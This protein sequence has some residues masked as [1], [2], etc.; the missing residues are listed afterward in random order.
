MRQ[1]KLT[2]GAG[3]T[4]DL[5]RRD[6]FFHAPAG[7]GFS[8]SVSALRAGEAWL[9]QEDE[10]QQPAPSGELI[11]AGYEQYE[12]FCAFIAEGRLSLWY[13]PRSTW[14]SAPCIVTSLA[15][16]EIETSRRLICAVSFLLESAWTRREKLEI[17]TE[18]G[19]K[20]YPYTYPY[21]YGSPYGGSYVVQNG[22]QRDAAL[23]L[24]IFGPVENPSWSV[25]NNGAVQRGRVEAAVAMGNKIV[26]DSSDGAMEL[27][28]YTNS[29]VFVRDLYGE[30]D[31][32]T[33]R[34]VRAPPGESVVSF[35]QEGGSAITAAVE[36]TF[37]ADTV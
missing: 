33:V 3:H 20:I 18:Q 28:E 16:S 6:A 13:A 5:M 25:T 7:L 26:V 24:T 17:E 27:A 15:K 21:R 1:F 11:F 36:V 23:R 37:Y 14:Y 22:T 10:P 29:N 34:F 35:E 12:E 8:R 30:G 4:F 2:N 19:G 31:F 32:S 9:T